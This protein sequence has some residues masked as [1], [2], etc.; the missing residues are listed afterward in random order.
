MVAVV[1]RSDA[2]N[3]QPP[4]REPGLSRA[5]GTVNIAPGILDF[6]FRIWD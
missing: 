6:G 5:G 3:A 2:G 1:G 4:A